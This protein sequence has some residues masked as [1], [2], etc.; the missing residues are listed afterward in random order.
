MDIAII[1]GGAAG[2]ASAYYLSRNGHQVCVY[3]KQA[4]LG[5]NIRTL[6]KNVEVSQLDPS[7]TLDAGV[8]EFPKVFRHFMKLMEELSVELESVDMGSAVMLKD[9]RHVLSPTMIKRNIKGFRRMP[10]YFRLASVYVTAAELWLKTQFP[11]LGLGK[12]KLFGQPELHDKP[13]SYFVNQDNDGSNWFKSLV[14]YSYSI[15]FSNIGKVPAELAIASMKD[16]AWSDWVRIKGGVYTY[17]EKILS[18]LN[19]DVQCHA[20]IESVT[21]K[22]NLVQIKLKDEPVREFD[23]VVFATPPDQVLELLRDPSEEEVQR[24]SA[25]KGNHA[26][27]VIHTDSSMYDRYSVDQTSEFDFFETENGWG[28]NCSL[29]QLCGVHSSTHYNLSYNL[30][31]LIDPKKIVHKQ[32][33]QTPFYTVEAFRFRDDIIEANG[34]N[35]TYHA[36]AYLADGLHE[37]AI[38]SA[39][40][41]A[42]LIA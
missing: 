3:E 9:G 20:C 6:N 37:G 8:I 17:I 16:Y 24:F 33:H 31:S 39:C 11:G 35:N 22:N 1:G 13:L 28:Y 38:S 15:P 7:L 42:D 27:T 26:I 5:G 36:G 12:F 2:M 21:R 10:E 19:G 4:V 29:N 25:W 14:M 30:E 40:R 18:D 32:D 41:V 23:K 34:E